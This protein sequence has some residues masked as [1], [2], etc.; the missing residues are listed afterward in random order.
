VGFQPQGGNKPPADW[1]GPLLLTL[2]HLSAQRYVPQHSGWAAGTLEAV[3]NISC[4]LVL[5]VLVF[6]RV[7]ITPEALLVICALAIGWLAANLFYRPRLRRRLRDSGLVE[8]LA[9][10]QVAGDDILRAIPGWVFSFNRSLKP[11]GD[12]GVAIR[13][14]VDNLG[15]YFRPR[16]PHIPLRV[17]PIAFGLLGAIAILWLYDHWHLGSLLGYPFSL[18]SVEQGLIVVAAQALGGLAGYHLTAG[19]IRR[20][21]FFT[22][23]S[24]ALG[25]AQRSGA[26]TPLARSITVSHQP[27][28]SRLNSALL[29]GTRPV[30]ML[31]VVLWS[32]AVHLVTTIIYVANSI[33]LSTALIDHSYVGVLVYALQLITITVLAWLALRS[34][35][36]MRDLIRAELASGNLMLDIGVGDMS[37]REELAQASKQAVLPQRYR[38]GSLEAAARYAAR[39]MEELLPQLELRIRLSKYILTGL[40]ILVACWAATLVLLQAEVSEQGMVTLLGTPVLALILLPLTMLLRSLPRIKAEELARHVY[41]RLLM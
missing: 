9:S 11:A 30:N 1:P 18:D 26:E 36:D 23:L 8:Q 32:A 15:W 4:G 13:R 25:L 28:D 12:M 2:R 34:L 40:W 20:E 35:G 19:R 39:H 21:E 6:L 7:L 38:P 33:S 24:E 31:A 16:K 3:R 17:L 29:D 22:A 10:G 5:F 41:E 14:L 27:L 37:A